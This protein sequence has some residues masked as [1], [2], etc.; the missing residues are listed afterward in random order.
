MLN[1]SSPLQSSTSSGGG[2]STRARD[3]RERESLNS[4]IQSSFAPRIPVEFNNITEAR[5]TPA[6]D[7]TSGEIGPV[8][9]NT[10]TLRYAV[11]AIV[12]G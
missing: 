12:D 5:P 4:S 8:R 1:G 10:M 2:S 7:N 9:S 3:A 6:S 11:C